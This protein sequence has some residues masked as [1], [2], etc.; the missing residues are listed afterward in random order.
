MKNFIKF[1]FFSIFFSTLFGSCSTSDGNGNGKKKVIS[2]ISLRFLDYDGTK[3]VDAFETTSFTYLNGEVFRMTNSKNEFVTFNYQG[4]KLISITDSNSTVDDNKTINIQYSGNQLKKSTSN[5]IMNEI[6]YD[7]NNRV[8]EILTSYI[9]S[10]FTKKYSK[11][12]YYS[13]NNIVSTSSYNIWSQKDEIASYKYDTKK[14]PYKNLNIYFR[15]FMGEI[16]LSENNI[17]EENRDN[18]IIKYSIIYDSD[19]FPLKVTGINQSTGKL[20]SE[21]TYIYTEI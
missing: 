13:G 20:W 14:N 8:N 5:E 3:E 1:I 16:N 21:Y 2:K 15:F 17:I 12:Y 7:S 19:D 9:D 11:K 4:N 10:N 18:E 6:F